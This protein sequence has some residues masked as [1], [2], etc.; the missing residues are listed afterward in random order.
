MNGFSIFEY[1]QRKDFVLVGVLAIRKMAVERIIIVTGSKGGGGKTPVSLALTILLEELNIQVLACDFN[2]NNAD[3]F[4]ILQGSEV[5][6]R[7]KSDDLQP[8][9]YGE[10]Q[11]WKLRDNLWLTPWNFVVKT[12]M[13]STTQMWKK[14][15]DLCK[16]R[17]M[18]FEPKVL[19]LDTN[20]TLPLICPPLTDIAELPQLP[21]V[22]VWHMW[23]PSIT[24]QI[25]EQDRFSTAISILNRLSKGFEERLH[26]VFSPRHYKTTSFMNT[27]SSITKGEFSIVKMKKFKQKNPTPVMFSELSDSLFASF[28]PKLLSQDLTERMDTEELIKAWLGNILE[29][30]KSRETR[31]NNVV[32]IPTIIHKIAM[33]VEELT[34]NPNR[35]LDS[36]K[37]EL[38]PLFEIIKEHFLRERKDFILRCG[39]NPL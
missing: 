18:D 5:E 38:G 8:K 20:L 19:V 7:V 15:S 23:S 9:E 28:I 35:T 29:T 31:A 24:L 39:G 4:S 22:E 1:M 30:L 3:L 2:F 36:M 27:L 32:V 21:P 26:H 33:L 16:F 6:D 11:F 10:D 13:P 12:G 25:G 34:L 37:L 14:I 17:Y